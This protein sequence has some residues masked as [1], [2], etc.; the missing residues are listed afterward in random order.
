[1]SLRRASGF[2]QPTLEQIRRAEEKKRASAKRYQEKL[3][4]QQR[5]ASKGP[6]G[7]MI[8]KPKVV[9]QSRGKEDQPRKKRKRIRPVN[10]KRKARLF[11]LQFLS[12]EY[13][14]FIH[15]QDCAVPGCQRRDIACAHAGKTRA[16]GGRWYEIAPLCGREGPGHHQEQE[17]R[18][19]WFNRKYCIDLLDIAARLALRWKQKIKPP[20]VT[21]P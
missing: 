20:E 19:E 16:N 2:A 5:K 13:V 10:E 3:R 15:E 1:M 12:S 11:A 14:E 7:G 18:T 8:R 6:A 9:L 4:K 17:G 21:T